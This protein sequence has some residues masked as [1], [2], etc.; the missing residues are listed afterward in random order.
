[1]FLKTQRN[2]LPPDSP[3]KQRCTSLL[4]FVVTFQGYDDSKELYSALIPKTN[5]GKHLTMLENIQ[6]VLMPKL[7][8]T[9]DIPHGVYRLAVCVRMCVCVCVCTACV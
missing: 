8:S 9:P 1:M 4:H 6:C 3:P 2:N 5:K 7:S